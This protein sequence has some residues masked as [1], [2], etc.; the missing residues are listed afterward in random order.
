MNN[1]P[2]GLRVSLFDSAACPGLGT[3]HDTTIIVNSPGYIEFDSLKANQGYILVIDENRNPC[4]K[5]LC[6]LT[7][8]AQGNALPVH[9]LNFNVTSLGKHKANIEWTLTNDDN[10]VSYELWKTEN[11][12]KIK[13][14]SYLR[15]S[16]S[17]SRF[18]YTDN[19]ILTYP[20]EYVVYSQLSS[21]VLKELGS[22]V[23]YQSDIANEFVIYPNPSSGNFRIHSNLLEMHQHADIMIFNHLGEM[24]FSGSDINLSLQPEIQVENLASGLYFARIYSRNQWQ[25]IAFEINK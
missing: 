3:Q 7:F 24:V 12:Q 10:V 18:S 2:F 14:Q 6:D 17:I 25:T 13:L 19:S 16:E 22:R 20:V 21:G 11:G 4:A 15:P 8:R 1:C 23:L 5:T 9:L